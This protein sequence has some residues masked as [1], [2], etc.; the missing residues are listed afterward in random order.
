MKHLFQPPDLIV[1]KHVKDFIKKKFTEWFSRQ[2]QIGL[3]RGAELENID[4]ANRLTVIKP[5]H[6]RWMVELYNH[7]SSDAGLKVV[8]S[9]WK[10]AGIF[11]AVRMGSKTF[12]H[13]IL[14][15][16]SIL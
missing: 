3:D 8:I 2:M 15:P 6:A 1:N 11:D 9:G 16:I 10:T 4:I 13:L 14:S 12:L 7:M 5:L